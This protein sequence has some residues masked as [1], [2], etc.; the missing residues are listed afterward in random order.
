MNSGTP[1]AL[2]ARGEIFEP[3][4]RGSESRNDK[5]IG[6]GLGLSIVSDCARL[7]GGDVSIIDHNA[8]DVVFRIR[9]PRRDLL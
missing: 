7:L 3:F 6:A 4:K 1:I 8:A 2:A 9:L 5:V